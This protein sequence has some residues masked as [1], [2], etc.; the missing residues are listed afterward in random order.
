MREETYLSLGHNAITEIYS[1][2]SHDSA[3]RY[4]SE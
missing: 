1:P 3:T 2:V 4:E